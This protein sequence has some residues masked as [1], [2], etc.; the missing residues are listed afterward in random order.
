[1]NEALNDILWGASQ[2]LY[3]HIVY[4]LYWIEKQRAGAMMESGF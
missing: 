3:A 2:T 4:W 1:M